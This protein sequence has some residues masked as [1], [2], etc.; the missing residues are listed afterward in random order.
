MATIWRTNRPWYLRLFLTATVLLA[1]YASP[2]AF[3][4]AKLNG[5]RIDGALVPGSEILKGGPP[6]DGI[7]SIDKPQFVRA[8][9]AAFLDPED[10][11]L[12]VSINGISKA[13]PVKILNFHEIVNDTIGGQSIVVTYCPLCGSG[14]AFASK[15]GNSPMTFG[16]SGLLYNSDVLLYD[17]QTESLWSQ[18]RRQAI[19][20]PMKGEMLESLPVTHTTWRDWRARRPDS[21]VLST[22]TGHERNYNVNPYPGYGQDG[23]LYFPVAVEDHRYPRKAIVMGLEIDG[24]FKA[25]PFAELSRGPGRIDDEFQGRFIEI[26]FDDANQTAS[27]WGEDGAEL[28]TVQAFWFAWFAFHPDTEVYRNRADHRE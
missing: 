28:P 17:R 18:L 20:G 4:A 14:M 24:R 6:R 22:K 13:Y 16:V 21:R 23:R 10:R 3:A 15:I 7:P 2:Q 8:D 25:Y 1:S 19:S 11:V 9:K 12:G 5:F 26:V 27:A